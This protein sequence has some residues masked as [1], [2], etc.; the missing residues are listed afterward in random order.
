M[1][2]IC[3][4]IASRGQLTS[5]IVELLLQEAREVDLHLH[6]SSR[7]IL[8]TGLCLEGKKFLGS[9]L[10]LPSM[11]TPAALISAELSVLLATA[12]TYSCIRDS[13][14]LCWTHGSGPSHSATCHV[15]HSINRTIFESQF[16]KMISFE[17]HSVNRT[18]SESVQ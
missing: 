6:D 14:E 9:H 3:P 2:W 8:S 15:L 18:S 1:L 17:F 4:G 10:A 11:M 7:K 13:P 12:S 5:I 16:I